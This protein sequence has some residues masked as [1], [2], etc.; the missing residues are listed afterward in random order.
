MKRHYYISLITGFFGVCAEGGFSDGFLNK[1]RKDGIHIWNMSCSANGKMY[2]CVPCKYYYAV[3]ENAL[4]SGVSVKITGSFGVLPFLKKKWKI[5]NGDRF[6]IKGGNSLNNQ[7]PFN[8]VIATKLYERI[9]N[10]GEYVPYF[11]I[12]DNGKTYSACKT[13]VSTDEELVS[14]LAIIRTFSPFVILQTSS[15]TV[16]D[17]VFSFFSKI[18]IPL[19]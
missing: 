13:M 18:P 9:L 12:N 7:E 4:L 6:L 14:G 11:L 16:C 17:G 8:E 19:L 3:A 1:C 15:T 5:I 2:F 10:E